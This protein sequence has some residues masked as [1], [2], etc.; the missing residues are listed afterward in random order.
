MGYR[1]DVVFKVTPDFDKEIREGKGLEPEDKAELLE[2][3]E[4][5][6]TDRTESYVLY[7]FLEVKWYDS[8]PD[9]DYLNKL[10][11]NPDNCKRFGGARIGEEMDDN[12]IMGDSWTFGISID[13]SISID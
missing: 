5:G 9:I 4:Q 12:D 2:F 3:L 1:S 11:N 6:E 8:Y 13:R 7:Q 10:F